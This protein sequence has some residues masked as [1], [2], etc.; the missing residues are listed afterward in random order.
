[1]AFTNVTWVRRDEITAAKLQ[2]MAD[3]DSDLNTR[4]TNAPR[5]ILNAARI[6]TAQSNTSVWW[7]IPGLTC[8]ATYEAG[9]TIRAS[10]SWGGLYPVG[11][12]GIWAVQIQNNSSGTYKVIAEAMVDCTTDGLLVGGGSLFAIGTTSVAGTSTWKV[13]IQK[14]DSTI[15]GSIAWYATN[16]AP[17]YL[18]VEDIGVSMAF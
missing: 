8:A 13:A 14:Q 11:F 9:R 4:L 1:M 2:A 7:D 6:K 15:G 3:N 17:S 16:D 12:P 5:G 18:L 10:V